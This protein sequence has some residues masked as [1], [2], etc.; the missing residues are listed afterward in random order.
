MQLFKTLMSQYRY[1]MALLIVLGFL[2]GV[3]EGL[4]ITAIIP[5][6]SYLLG[7]DVPVGNKI[8][9]TIVGLFDYLPIAYSPVS[10]LL[11]VI[12]LFIVRALVMVA[13]F[14]LRSRV[15][16]SYMVR[17]MNDL[18]NKVLHAKW[19][20]LLHQ[21]LGTI[22][23][24]ISRDVRNGQSLLENISQA[25]LVFTNLIIYISLA[26]YISPAITL[27]TAVAG[28]LMLFVLRPIRK[29]IKKN[30]R[31]LSGMEKDMSHFLNEHTLGLK[32]VKSAAV[33]SAVY[34]AGL[35]WFDAFKQLLIKS[36][37]FG[38]VSSAFTQPVALIFM[39]IVFLFFYGK[40]TLELGTFIALIYLIQKIF[41]YVESGQ[42]ALHSIQDRLP[43]AEHAAEFAHTLATEA[44]PD[45]GARRFGFQRAIEF[46][47][48]GFSYTG[49]KKVLDDASFSIVKGSLTGLIGP[50]GSGKTSIADLLLRLFE[51]TSGIISIDGEDIRSFDISDWRR[52]IGYVSQDMFLLN[53]TVA[54]NIRFYNSE[55]SDENVR[56]AARFANCTEFIEKLPQKF[57]TVIGERGIM[58]SLGQRQ[59]IIL[60]RVLARK[61]EIL[62]LD[63]ATSALDNES[64]RL[65]QEAIEGLKQNI[66]IFII[67]HR[68]S[69][70]RGVDMLLVLQ[71]GR[72][73]ERGTP[74]ELLANPDSYFS[75]MYKK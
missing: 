41:A 9:S 57:E 11:F 26:V 61:P 72:L 17:T 1:H 66:T 44:E 38:A 68:L 59:R 18:W 33:E 63:E 65:V 16:S 10:L 42:V 4:G 52:S 20:F 25:V 19:G 75:R 7:Q 45:D 73:E 14:Y 70:V 24:T 29:R 31:A 6:F 74:Q 69:T 35:T 22:D 56:E 13:F 30:S 71:N 3:L 54:A 34:R 15:S 55:M 51:P 46:S 8:V 43:Y 36:V 21:R 58:L 60:A 40:G 32:A 5:L 27:A 37:F 12:V 62:I 49:E 39:T 47:H 2:S 23:V 67:A 64:E 28:T 53:D 50:S 48:V